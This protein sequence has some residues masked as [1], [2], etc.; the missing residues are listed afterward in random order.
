M[1]CRVS[2]SSFQALVRTLEETEMD[3][4]ERQLRAE[5][6]AWKFIAWSSLGL[7]AFT[8][9]MWLFAGP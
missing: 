1:T 9:A 4:V 2:L 8:V 5:L 7:C 6:R 3:E